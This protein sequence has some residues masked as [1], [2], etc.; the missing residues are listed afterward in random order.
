MKK[1][2]KEGETRKFE[3]YLGELETIVNNLEEGNLDLETSLKKYE[4]GV[5]ALKQCYEILDS[6]EKRIEILTK[7][8]DGKLQSKPFKTKKNNLSESPDENDNDNED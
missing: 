3:D 1:E 5:K 4:E 8:A 7:D 2:R 6:M